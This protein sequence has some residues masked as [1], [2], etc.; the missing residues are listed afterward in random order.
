[1]PTYEYL[2]QT[3]SHRFETWQKMTAEPLTTCPECGSHIR[4]VLYPAGVVLTRPIMI[5]KVRF[6]PTL[7]MKAK[8]P[9]APTAMQAL[10]MEKTK[11]ETTKRQARPVKVP[12]VLQAAPISRIA[13]MVLMVPVVHMRVK[14][15]QRQLQ[16]N[17]DYREGAAI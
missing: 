3:C 8:R 9:K 14:A 17:K 1:M 13:L 2:C 12:I 5:K 15:S 4:R 6:S 16:R 11:Q 10:L 7:M